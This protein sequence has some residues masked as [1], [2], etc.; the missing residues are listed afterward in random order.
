[1]KARAALASAVQWQGELPPLPDP[2]RLSEAL[3]TWRSEDSVIG[4]AGQD[5]P[6][7][8]GRYA[9]LLR[10]DLTTLDRSR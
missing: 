8:A 6:A 9:E 10:S 3:R 4:S 7:P 2:A 1:M 5:Q